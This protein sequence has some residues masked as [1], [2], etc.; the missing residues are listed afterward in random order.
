MDTGHSKP[1]DGR[2]GVDTHV[3]HLED[4]SDHEFES[5][6]SVLEGVSEEEAA[7]QAPCYSAEND[8]WPGLR[9]GSIHWHVWHLAD[10]KRVYAAS[11]R[12]DSGAV[13]VPE[14][15]PQF[16]AEWRRLVE[17]HHEQVRALSSLTDED[18]DRS[19]GQG[20]PL[21]KQVA[22]HVRHDAW[23]GGQIALIRRLYRTRSG[24]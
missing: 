14:P 6:R 12:N 1:K 15:L 10:C 19:D 22:A 20:P 5:L 17:E 16:G 13:E 4:A 2:R 23:H 21:G 11:Y 18:L 24:S 7:W 9:T 3:A 8:E